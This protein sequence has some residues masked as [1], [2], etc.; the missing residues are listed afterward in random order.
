MFNGLEP[1]LGLLDRDGFN[2]VRV[3]TEGAEGLL[4]FLETLALLRHLLFFLF[5]FRPAALLRLLFLLDLLTERLE[6]LL[7]NPPF[8]LYG[9]HFVHHV[10]QNLLRISHAIRINLIPNVQLTHDHVSPSVRVI[11]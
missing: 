1:A 6:F 5:K 2:H 9:M 3:H 10:G 4:V 11:S 7:R 8:F